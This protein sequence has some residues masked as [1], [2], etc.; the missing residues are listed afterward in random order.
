MTS[1]IKYRCEITIKGVTETI[2]AET[3]NQN[4]FALCTLRTLNKYH[5][6][7][8]FKLFGCLKTVTNV[9]SLTGASF[10][11]YS[12]FLF[13]KRFMTGKHKFPLHNFVNRNTT[14]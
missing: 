5:T 9:S 6:L 3:T 11:Q 14:F 12:R 10:S 2:R 1:N 8:D 13:E 7:S 4:N